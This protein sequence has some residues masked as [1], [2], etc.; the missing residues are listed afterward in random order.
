MDV[1]KIHKS[2]I[3]IKST[4]ETLDP[5]VALSHYKMLLKRL[6]ES[7]GCG[8]AESEEIVEE[9]WHQ[10]IEE[11]FFL[12]NVKKMNLAR[13]IVRCC[14]VRQGRRVFNQSGRSATDGEDIS[15]LGL[16]ASARLQK[17]PLTFKV[18]YLLVDIG[19]FNTN[20]IATILNITAVQVN[21][22]LGKA[23]R[24]LGRT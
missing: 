4:E 2:S 1:R 6:V 19:G 13:D 24:I 12:T 10:R 3:E 11:P 16:S 23:K 14:V 17:M 22:R 9:V 5:S 8:S 18:V 7:F 20:E 15:F 21:E